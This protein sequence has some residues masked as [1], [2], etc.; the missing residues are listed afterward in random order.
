MNSATAFRIAAALGF[1]GVALG[2]FGAHAWQDRL[3]ALDTVKT[4]GTASLYHLV[5]AVVLLVVSREYATRKLGW[6]SFFLGMLVFSGSLYVLSLSGL[7]WLGAITPLGGLALLVGWGSL[8]YAPSP[9]RVPG[10]EG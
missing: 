9:R 5:H 1:A 3:V 4:W 10:C 2:A 6:W 8:V 7:K